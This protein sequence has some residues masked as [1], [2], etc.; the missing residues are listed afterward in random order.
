MHDAQAAAKL[1]GFTQVIDVLDHI[2]QSGNDWPAFIIGDVDNQNIKFYRAGQKARTPG[3]CSIIDASDGTFLGSVTRNGA[4]VPSYTLR[5]ATRDFKIAFWA[6]LKDL[7]H[8]AEA[9][10]AENGKKLGRCCLCHRPL[11]DQE[12]VELGIGPVCRKKAGWA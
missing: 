8:D 2:F 9:T 4:F 10:L 12:S 6:L 7:R 5:C 3:S 11:S 1:Q